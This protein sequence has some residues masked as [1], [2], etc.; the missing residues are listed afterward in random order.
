MTTIVSAFISNVNSNRNIENYIE[1]GKKLC[2]I[3]INKVIFIE[4]HIYNTYFKNQTFPLTIFI[5][6]SKLIF[7][8]YRQKFL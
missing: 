8:I 3:N 7:I 4:E 5:F 2:S 1:Y 6:I